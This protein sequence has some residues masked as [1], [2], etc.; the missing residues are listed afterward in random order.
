MATVVDRNLS[1]CLYDNETYKFHVCHI[2]FILQKAESVLHGLLEES[3]EVVQVWYMLG[4]VQVQRNTKESKPYGRY[5]LNKAK[6]V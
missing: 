5:Y 6:K 4:L 3:D 1:W 2:K